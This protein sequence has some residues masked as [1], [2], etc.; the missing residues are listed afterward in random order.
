[1]ES[2]YIAKTI[3]YISLVLIVVGALNWGLYG[4]FKFDLVAWLGQHSMPEI[5]TIIYILIGAAALVHIFSRDYYLRFL[6]DSA[7]PCGSLM[8][9]EPRD[10][11]TEV[12]IKVEPFVNVIYWASEP[13]NEVVDNPWTA[14]NVFSNTGVARSDSDGHAVLRFRKPAAYKVPSVLKDRKLQPHVHYRVCKSYGMMGR[15][16]TVYM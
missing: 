3:E 8:V 13:N 12:A 11:D 14:Y 6:G 15:V 10:A 4:V 2:I 1:M 5:A 16:E 9:K 7:F